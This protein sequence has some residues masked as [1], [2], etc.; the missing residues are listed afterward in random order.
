[1]SRRVVTTQ[2]EGVGGQELDTYFDKLLK[3]I[4]ADIVGA[5]IAAAGLIES[6]AEG[7]QRKVLLWIAFLVGAPLAGAWT[8]RQT[9]A[10][11]RPP[12]YTQAALAVGSFVVWIFAIGGPFSTLSWYDAL[13]GSLVLILYTIVVGFVN[14]P[15]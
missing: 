13:Y 11:N 2:L 15:E 6:G 5:W 4:P 9:Q 12:A 1:M 10:P 7:T 14:P 8:L 3:Y